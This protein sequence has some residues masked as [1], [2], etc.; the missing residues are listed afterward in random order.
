MASVLVLMWCDVL[1]AG[2]TMARLDF[3]THSWEFHKESIRL[4]RELEEKRG[5]PMCIALDTQGASVC[6]GMLKDGPDARIQV[7][8]VWRALSRDVR[9]K[10][11]LNENTM[12]K[13]LIYWLTYWLIDWL[14]RL[15]YWSADCLLSYLL[16][17]KIDWLVDWFI[18]WLVYCLA[19]CLLEVLFDWLFGW[20]I[21]C[22]IDWSIGRSVG[23]SV[24]R[25]VGRSVG[26][27][28]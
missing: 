6:T 1:H 22:I 27:S 16:V 18:N 23:R 26:R 10:G 21:E 17:W 5:R 14:N 8:T 4:L 11:W 28:I 9:S 25:S 3:S 2:M 19:T 24:D 13:W 20:M 7:C 15:I 12:N